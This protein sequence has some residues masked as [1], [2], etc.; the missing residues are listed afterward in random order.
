MTATFC[1]SKCDSMAGSVLYAARR[2]VN[3]VSCC[4]M[5]QCDRPAQ[6]TT[7]RKC[8]PMV[9]GSCVKVWWSRH[10]AAFFRLREPQQV[11]KLTPKTAKKKESARRGLERQPSLKASLVLG[12]GKPKVL[13]ILV[14]VS[15]SLL[16]LLSLCSRACS[17]RRFTAS[18][19]WRGR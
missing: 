1:R 16:K 15:F 5:G 7:T 3:E 8:T 9:H 6:H 2:I 4:L 10:E 11:A 12:L 17:Y 13:P 18:W 19:K 14:Y